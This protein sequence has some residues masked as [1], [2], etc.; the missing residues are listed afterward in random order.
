MKKVLAIVSA[1]AVL[2]ASI[3]AQAQV[4]DQE[5]VLFNH[6][7]IGVGFGF[8]EGV[9]I[10]AATT[11]LPNLQAR[12]VYNSLMPVL[13]IGDLILKKYAPE[14]TLNPFTANVAVGVHSTDPRIDIDEVQLNGSI[15]DRSIGILADFFPFKEAAFHITGGVLFN[16]HPQF[17]NVSATPVP[18][19][20]KNDYASTEFFGIT[21]DTEGNVHVALQA[22]LNV[23]QP[24]LGIG[25]GR[26]ISLKS[27]VSFNFDLGVAYIGGFHLF[28]KNYY[29]N[30]EKPKNVELN[31]AW[32]DANPDIKDSMGADYDKIVKYVNMVNNFPVM[33][34]M[35]FTLAVRLF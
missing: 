10:T 3:S 7:S 30:P 27:R 6:W 31:Q 1:A 29:E 26:P 33:P 12:V 18:A 28:S 13:A 25:F 21:T 15:Q 2:L 20:D 19:L 9:Q 22:G 4:K 14:Y 8:S 16:I 24:Y 17:I 23:V 35:R 11:V 34:Y 32:I 5:N